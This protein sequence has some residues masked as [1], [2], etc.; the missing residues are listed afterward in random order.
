MQE[1]EERELERRDA[2]EEGQEMKMKQLIA[3][4]LSKGK[5]LEVIAEELEESVETVRR[6]SES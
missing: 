4:K 1:W 3:K 5:S 6:L 2:W